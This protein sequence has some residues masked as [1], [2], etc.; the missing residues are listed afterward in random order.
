MCGNTSREQP[1]RSCRCISRKLR[2]VVERA[3]TL[4]L[5]DDERLP[6]A[7]RRSRRCARCASARWAVIR[8]VA[9]SSTP[10]PWR[11][12]IAEMLQAQ[13]SERQGRVIDRDQ[14][15]SMEKKK[16]EGYF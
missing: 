7:I 1:S 3:G 12:V 14:P 15:G 11:P 9:P 2:P 13:S 10:T 5:Q 6:L 16:Q 4:I 8:S